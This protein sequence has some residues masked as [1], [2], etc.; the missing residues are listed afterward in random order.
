MA[1]RYPLRRLKRQIQAILRGRPDLLKPEYRKRVE[2]GAHPLTGHCYVATEV[3]YHAG[4]RRMGFRPATVRQVG[5]VHW[6][7]V[8]AGGGVLDP[9][10]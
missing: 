3:L 6:F 1:G 8:N 5:G 7:L 4:A 9:H 10:E 2:A